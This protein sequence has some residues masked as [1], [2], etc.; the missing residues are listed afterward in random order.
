MLICCH[1]ISANALLTNLQTRWQDTSVASG[2]LFFRLVRPQAV[3][4][5]FI[6]TFGTDSSF[7]FVRKMTRLLVSRLGT[8]KH[9]DRLLSA[10]AIPIV[11]QSVFSSSS[12]K[13]LVCGYK[14]WR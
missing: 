2:K 1:L 13:E 8:K 12:Y 14:W 11:F 10:G 3:Q 5:L 6:W 7:C 4:A 9:E